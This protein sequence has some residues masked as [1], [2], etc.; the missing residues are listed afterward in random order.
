MKVAECKKD[1]PCYKCDN[2]KCALSGF[3]GS[4]C[5]KIFCDRP[6]AFKFECNRCGF[7][8]KYIE[9]IYGNKGGN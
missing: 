7:I 5:P 9:D 4:D 2:K 1:I 3:K 8:D 6:E